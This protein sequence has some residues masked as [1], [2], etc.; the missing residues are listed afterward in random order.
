[1]WTVIKSWITD[2]LQVFSVKFLRE[3]GI[4]KENLQ[5]FSYNL[6]SSS[7]GNGCYKVY[8]FVYALNKLKGLIYEYLHICK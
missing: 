2:G 4:H 7:C 5:S 8:P 3:L 6:L 1:M